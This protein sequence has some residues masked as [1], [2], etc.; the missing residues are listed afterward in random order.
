MEARLGED[1]K[2]EAR[3]GEG[4]RNGGKVRRRKK[5]WRQG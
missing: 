4:R 1:E 5:K 2:M 3:L